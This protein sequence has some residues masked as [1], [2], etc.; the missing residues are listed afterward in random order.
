MCVCERERERER[1]AWE[2]GRE[3]EMS[4]NRK[5]DVGVRDIWDE[6]KK[7]EDRCLWEKEGN[8]DDKKKRGGGG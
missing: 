4:K 1:E 3:I 7:E 5:I 6:K 2:R 8:W